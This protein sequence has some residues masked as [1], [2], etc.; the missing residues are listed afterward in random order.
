MVQA[1]AG[2]AWWGLDRKVL[3]RLCSRVPWWGVAVLILL[4]A[5]PL[6]AAA[7]P[8]GQAAAPV[9]PV[10]V[11][12]RPLANKVIVIDP[13]HGGPDTGT[14]AGGIPEKQ[15]NL[16]IALALKPML[17]AVGA[18]TIYTRTSDRAVTSGEYSQRADLQA[19]VDLANRSGADLFISI[20]ADAHADP[21][22]NGVTVY[23]G[24]DDGYVYNLP[25]PR[26]ADLTRLSR[27]LAARLLTEL[28]AATG[29]PDRGV[30]QRSFYVLGATRMP[31]ALVEVGY[32]TNGT[33][34]ARLRDPV[35]QQRV[36]QGLLNGIVSYFRTV[37][38]AR[39]VADVTVP[40]GAKM[41]QGASFTKTW[42]L[43]NTGGV[44]WTG[45]HRLVFAGGAPLGLVTSVPVPPV[46]PGGS[47]EVSVPMRVPSGMFGRLQSYWRMATPD[48]VPFGD[49]LWVEIVT[50]SP[51]DRA[52][53][54]TG[55]PNVEYFEQTGHNVGYAFLKFFKANGGV[56]V[57]GYPRTEEITEDGMTVQYFQRA[58]FEY[59]PD[60]AGTPYEVQLTLLGDLLT[61]NRRPFPGV[62]P[63]QSNAQHRYF[64]ETGHSVHFAFL[65]FFNANGGVDVFG[66]PISEEIQEGNNDGSG[67]I[68]TV[69]YFQRARFEYH[70]EHA[71][72]P[73]EVQLGLLG[74][75]VLRQRGWLRE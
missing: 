64:P 59:H 44:P 30:R 18:R 61:S 27:Q 6:P 39:Y 54:I 26:S 9:P 31:A 5:Q 14:L 1:H 73:Y 19:R 33:D 22:I 70:P 66:Y 35:Y 71:G 8:A 42:R 63:F 16:A 49:R 40:D 12:A 29:S 69:Q 2:I 58:R 60:K 37:E 74:D 52:P 32:M 3:R 68:Y 13:G 41:P 72:T 21:T 10:D 53:P 17:E 20:H 67:R 15:V 36:A 65:K 47:I 11:A 48:G 55:N 34:A 43:Q 75:E 57:F 7:E 28:T 56:D 51:V 4:L 62:A 45:Q 38:D 23:Y 46:P 25:A 50:T 24:A